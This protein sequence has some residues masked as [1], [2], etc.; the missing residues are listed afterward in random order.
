MY[1]K[2]FIL[3]FLAHI[4][5]DFYFQSKKMA[6]QKEKSVYKV[7]LHSI[8]YAMAFFVVILPV[9][10]KWLVIAA[11]FISLSHLIIDVFKW[12]IV[13]RVSKVNEDKNSL[14]YVIDQI[15]HLIFIFIASIFVAIKCDSLNVFSGIN[16][17]FNIVGVN[18][19]HALSSLLLVLLVW[20][21]ANIT[22]KKIISAY[23]PVDDF[24]NK[25]V[26]NAGGIIGLLERIAI[27]LFL[28]INQYS[29]IGLV[30]TAKS[31]ARYNKISENKEFAEYYL[32]GTLLSTVIAVFSYFVIICEYSGVAEPPVR[33]IVS[34]PS[35][36]AEPVFRK[37]GQQFQ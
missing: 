9:I 12:V 30:L 3:L 34:H 2:I 6:E 20:K 16:Y 23:K 10:N 24:E 31:I 19:Q 21:P 37:G 33:F 14:V 28:S 1:K 4:I 36:L 29:A 32:I 18:K 25:A 22:I 7:L 15:I 17:I 5:G 13:K 35:G 11:T 27:L 8:F 26:I